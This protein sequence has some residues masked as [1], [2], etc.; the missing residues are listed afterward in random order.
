M[1][2]FLRTHISPHQPRS[3]NIEEFVNF[4]KSGKHG[5]PSGV[6]CMAVDEELGLLAIG[7]FNGE[8]KIYGNENFELSATI[9]EPKA[10]THIYFVPG[11]AELIAVS[12]ATGADHAFYKFEICGRVLKRTDASTHNCL[13]KI[14]CFEMANT[15][16]STNLLLG[17]VTGNVFALSPETLELEEFVIFDNT[18]LKNVNQLKDE[19]RSITKIIVDKT[20]PRKISLIFNSSVIV[21]YDLHQQTVSFVIQAP[22]QLSTVYLD[23]DHVY[24]A[25]KDGSY[26]KRSIKGGKPLESRMPFGPYPCTP[27]EKLIILTDSPL[28]TELAIFS[29][30]MPNASYGDRFT[31]SLMSAERNV[32]LDLGS[33]VIDFSVIR[34]SDQIP[35]ALLVLCKEEFV[36]IDLLDSKWRPFVLPYLFPLHYAPLTCLTVVDDVPDHVW[37]QLDEYGVKSSGQVSPKSWPLK[38]EHSTAKHAQPNKPKNIYLTGHEDGNINVWTGH[39]ESL[40]RLTSI[41]CCTLFEGYQ[42]D[43]RDILD[44]CDPTDGAPVSDASTSDVDAM[45]SNDWPPFRKTGF[46][47]MFCDDQ[48]IA[49]SAVCFNTSTGDIAAATQGGQIMIFR[50]SAELQIHSSAYRQ[51]INLFEDCVKKQPKKIATVPPRNSAFIYRKGYQPLVVDQENRTMSLLIQMEPA[52][53]TTAI[54]YTRLGGKGIVTVGNEHGFVVVDTASTQT[55]YRRCLATEIEQTAV[56]DVSTMS[57]FKSMKKSIR[58]S[59]RRKKKTNN[60]GTSEQQNEAQDELRPVERKIVGRSEMISSR[61]VKVIPPSLVRIVRFSKTCTTASSNENADSLW[62]GTYGGVVYMLSIGVN[63]MDEVRCSLMKELK[64]KHGAPVVGIDTCHFYHNFGGEDSVVNRVVISTEEQMRSYTLPSLK[65][66]RFKCKLAGFEGSR[67]RRTSVVRLRSKHSEHY[68]T[69]LVATS[70]RGEFFLFPTS[71]VKQHFKPTD[72]AEIIS[73]VV[74]AN[75]DVVYALPA[76]SELQRASLSAY[77]S[78]IQAEKK[79]SNN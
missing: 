24:C 73:T 19:D 36:A 45:E 63:E 62:I 59:F 27:I 30:G 39:Q 23:G 61:E 77:I 76:A 15:G 3:E 70:S 13:K 25:Y 50:L 2:R 58:K 26:E 16:E 57:R 51:T 53:P 79:P 11:K 9:S 72:V 20:D 7:T 46:Y 33:A 55:I 75:G 41:N 64:L 34:N 37:K 29:G 17:T 8:V 14:T 5:F 42:Q 47:D 71:S 10:L 22:Q 4:T 49:I 60:D 1:L 18:Q 69:F 40:R 67:I 31:V 6:S 65:T 12:N 32:V 68:E 44:S 66:S 21:S 56:T 38:Y 54:A 78:S 48:Q 28:A 52:L 43:G 74:L 35:S